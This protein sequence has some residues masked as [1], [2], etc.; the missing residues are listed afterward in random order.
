MP[1]TRKQY[2]TPA[3]EKTIGL[4][5]R[6]L[7]IRRGLTQVE[8]A[9]AV[10]INQSALSDYETGTVRLHAALVAG[11][12]KALKASAD[13]ILG[14]QAPKQ[15]AQKLDR[16][17]LRRIEKIEELPKHKK[18]ALLTTIDAFLTESRS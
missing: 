9:R 7:R 5:L 1:R 16:R 12:A 2:V 6:D 13:E 3:S 18:Q 17:F 15:T 10:G 4:R 8:L 14:L 11:F